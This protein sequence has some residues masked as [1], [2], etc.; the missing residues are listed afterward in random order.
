MESKNLLNGILIG[1]A[2]GVAIGIL[3]A[4]QSGKETKKKLLNAT[5][6]FAQ[7]IKQILKDS[8]LAWKERMILTLND[9]DSI[10]S[11]TKDDQLHA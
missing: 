6:Q 3:V 11:S 8:A 4:P 9:P 7:D 5:D 10:T 1:A 2:V